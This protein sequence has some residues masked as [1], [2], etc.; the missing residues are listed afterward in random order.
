MLNQ[1]LSAEEVKKKLAQVL[2][3]DFDFEQG[4][5]LGSMCTL[6]HPLAR[7][8]FASYLAKNVGDPGLF[9]A[10]VEL[11]RETI[12]LL[13]ELLSHKKASGFI[14]TGGSESN[15]VALWTAKTLHRGKGNEV[16]IPASA[17]FC[18]DKAATLL[19]LKIKKIKLDDKYTVSVAELKKQITA[20]TIALVG[21]AGTTA[22]GVVDPIHELSDLA[23]QYGLY[24]HIDAAFGGFVLPFLKDLG[25]PC[26]AYDFSLKGVSSIT[27]DPHKMGMAVIPAGGLLYRSG[28]LAAAVKVQVPYLSGGE[29]AQA[30]IVGTRSGASVLATWA[31][32][33]HLGSRGYKEIV[34][35]CLKLTDYLASAIRE[36]DELSL[37]TEP[38]LNIVGISSRRISIKE[39]VKR[40]RKKGWALSLFPEHI[41]VVLMPHLKS[42]HI[43]GFISD[44]K[45][46]VSECRKL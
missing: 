21:I 4:K 13:G 31:V 14:L 11:E 41:R 29:S 17:H 25:R 32:L 27:I 40:L 45:T 39:L 10:T 16:L 33:K 9:P 30:T 38:V 5:I 15:I 28:K 43:A 34:K 7:E 42:D 22:L 20:K 46:A 19:D 23:R 44:L 8:I 37:T 36:I 6:P 3:K 1:S 12:S 26:P 35:R 18:F 2:K 24:L